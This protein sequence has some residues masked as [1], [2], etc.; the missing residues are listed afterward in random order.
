M[1]PQFSHYRSQWEGF[2]KS[3]S[4][5][6]TFATP[7]LLTPEPVTSFKNDC[8]Y[9]KSACNR[10][11]TYTAGCQ[12]S[13]SD[14]L[15]EC[16]CQT[17]VVIMESICSVDGIAMCSK[18]PIEDGG[19]LWGARSCNGA[20]QGHFTVPEWAFAKATVDVPTTVPFA[21][22]PMTYNDIPTESA[23]VPGLAVREHETSML[24]MGIC[25]LIASRW[26]RW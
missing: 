26:T 20:G 9:I 19:S 1:D 4:P 3:A 2:C 17:H 8:S 14:H 16:Y 5:D 22:F 23:S 12:S 21:K 25:L 6:I 7:S 13:F 10:Y 15:S 18:P 24:L 11:N